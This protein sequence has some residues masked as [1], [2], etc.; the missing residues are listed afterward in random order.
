VT[1][2]VEQHLEPFFGGRRAASITPADVR[3][4]TLSRQVERTPQGKPTSNATIN[5]ELS[6][7]KRAF[8]LGIDAGKL[9]HKPKIPM[10]K[11]NNVRTGSFER[12]Q[13]E[14]VQ[15][16]LAEPLRP[17]LS[18]GYVTGW[19]IHQRGVAVAVAA[20]GLRWTPF[21][22][23]PDKLKSLR[24]SGEEERWRSASSTVGNSRRG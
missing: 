19:R 1:H 4:Y 11:E 8:S 3:Q 15:V 16:K 9:T 13:F 6:A 20:S 10:L 18:F 7:L 2:N 21:F 5:R 24:R 17:A 14:A 23:Q 22:G 12:D